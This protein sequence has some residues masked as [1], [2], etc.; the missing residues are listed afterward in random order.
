[1]TGCSQ[2]PLS[3]SAPVNQ[4]TPA[5]IT[6]QPVS[7]T[8]PFGG[9][10]T[11]TVSAT[12]NVPLGYQWSKNGT[13]ISG[14]YSATYTTPPVSAADNGAVYAVVVSDTNLFT[15]SNSATLT[16]GA[17]SPKT[18][19]LRFQQVASPVD[20]AIADV[21]SVS[22]NLSTA[23]GGQATATYAGYL[24]SP[25]DI[26]T[27]AGTCDP[28]A[29]TS[30]VWG[31]SV[32]PIPASTTPITASYITGP[33]ASFASAIAALPASVSVVTSMDLPPAPSSFALA[34]ASSSQNAG[35]DTLL[36][37]VPPGAIQATVN[38]DGLKSRVVTAVTFDS[39]GNANLLSYGWQG[40]TTTLYDTTTAT[41]APANVAA[42][43]ASLGA[44]GYIITAFGGNDANTYVLVGTKVHGD[45]LPRPTTVITESGTTGTSEALPY[46]PL[47]VVSLGYAPASNP[48][49]YTS[50]TEVY[51]Q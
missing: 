31:Y 20:V 36:E 16:V 10:A 9:T 32:T 21:Q 49:S 8:V 6:A 33:S 3:Q 50:Y 41:V 30:C 42:A 40:D 35:F 45:T 26:G 46:N 28:T 43:A 11:F 17:R 14:A 15:T 23:P 12:G 27:A 2:A 24:G 4:A 47:C 29:P 48:Q 19:D 38:A 5:V 1:M 18:G 7:Q 37:V 13:A 51:Q 34:V 25:L 44:Q 39:S 22:Y